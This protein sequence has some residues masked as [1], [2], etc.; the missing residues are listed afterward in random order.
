MKTVSPSQQTQAAPSVASM[1][2][3]CMAESDQNIMLPV[4]CK[5]TVGAIDDPLEAEA[6][7][8]AD[9]VMRMPESSFI[10]RKCKHCEEEE[11]AQRKPLTSFIQRKETSGSGTVVSEAFGNQ[12]ASSRG[13]GDT[14]D[15]PVK[16][17]METRLGTDFS[18]VRIH[19]DHQAVAF[20]SALNAQAFTMGNDV[21]FNS[22]KYSPESSE[23]KHLLAHELTHVVQQQDPVISKKSFIQRIPHDRIHDPILDDF[24]RE[25]GVPRDRASQHSDEYRTWLSGKFINPIIDPSCSANRQLVIDTVNESLLWIDDI[26]RQLIGFAADQIFNTPGTTP[27]ADHTRIASALQQTFHTTDELYVQLLASR[28]YHIGRML[29]EPNRVTI[30]CGGDGCRA[31]G[32]SHVAAFVDT[33]Y[34][35]HICGTGRNIATFIHEMGHAVIPNVG[36]RN[37]VTQSNGI[38]DRA[39]DHERVFHHLTPEEALDNAESYGILAEA[40]RTRRTGNLVAPQP[41]RTNCTNTAFVLSAFARA[42]LWARRGWQLIGQMSGR[43]RGTAPLTDLP[44]AELNFLN[45]HLPLVTSTADLRAFNNLFTNLYTSSYH[46]SLGSVLNC[47]GAA[48]APC[49]S[50]AVGISGAGT[51]TSSAVSLGTQSPSGEI[52]FCPAWFTLSETDRIKTTFA[53]FLMGR[54]SWMHSGISM[55]NAFTIADFA[56]ATLDETLPAPTTRDAAEHFFRDQPTAPVT[57]P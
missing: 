8:V 56:K 2:S 34:Q 22:G 49:S 21:Y 14:M 40:L 33:P 46:S 41:D 44:A 55:T 25:T 29:R 10:Q 12:I 51:V 16:N 47:Q 23:E 17:F 5:L 20:S 6:D 15:K 24:S 31:S 53:L 26:Y 52:D 45:R 36:I 13:N 32:S 43:L 28:F 50:G 4:Q 11:K 35:I 3:L 7:A 39:Y 42:E 30:F 1:P 18:D 54:P 38:T 19:T 57:T 48:S 27:S 9:K 37:T